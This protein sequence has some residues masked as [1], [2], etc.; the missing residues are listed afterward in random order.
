MA[1]VDHVDGNP[2][3]AYT[4]SFRWVRNR[5]RRKQNAVAT[6]PAGNAEFGAVIK[7]GDVSHFLQG[8]AWRPAYRAPLRELPAGPPGLRPAAP[9][10]GLQGL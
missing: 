4:L 1:F 8:T 10:T 5:D 3:G 9:A 6:D 7:G 2:E